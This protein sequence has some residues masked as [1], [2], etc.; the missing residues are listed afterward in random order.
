MQPV[1]IVFTSKMKH[2]TAKKPFT[3]EVRYFRSYVLSRC[4]TKKVTFSLF[5]VSGSQFVGC[6]ISGRFEV[7]EFTCKMALSQSGGR[8]PSFL[9][10][11][12]S[13]FGSISPLV[14]DENF[15]IAPALLVYGPA[16]AHLQWALSFFTSIFEFL[17]FCFL[18]LT[19]SVLIEFLTFGPKLDG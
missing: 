17:Q 3:R 7:V 14:A 9:F 4:T 19:F 12:F 5:L 18:S 2:F 11:S 1:R 16:W 6:K 8:T 13:L 15:S 10:S